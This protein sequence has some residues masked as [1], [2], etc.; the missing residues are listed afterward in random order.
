ME[1]AR[2]LS[3]TL[4]ATIRLSPERLPNKYNHPMTATVI[5]N[6][7]ISAASFPMNERI[8]ENGLYCTGPY[9]H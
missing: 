3:S 6:I 1:Q 2:L 7:R 4:A 9:H 8:S 5:P